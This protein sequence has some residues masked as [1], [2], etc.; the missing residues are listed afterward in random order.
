MTVAPPD[1][2]E[3]ARAML[4][5]GVAQLSATA[6]VFASEFGDGHRYQNVRISPGVQ[7]AFGD[8]VKEF[9]RGTVREARLRPYEPSYKPDDDELLYIDVEETPQ[10]QPYLAP[11]A[12]AGSQQLFDESPD[13]ID[14]LRF[15]L[16]R[17]R[18]AARAGTFISSY[19]PTRE[20]TRSRMLAV[21]FEGGN[22]NR[23]KRRT[24]LFDG[25]FDCFE[26]AG[27]LFIKNPSRFERIFDYIAELQTQAE[28]ALVTI[29]QRVPIRDFDGLTAHALRNPQMTAKLASLAHRSYLPTLTVAALKAVIAEFP[30]LQQQIPIVT[31]G[32]VEKLVFD[33]APSRRWAILKLLDDD[34]LRSQMTSQHYEVNS[35]VPT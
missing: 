18:A 19:G 4:I 16:L 27:L 20:L 9:V 8:D 24:F 25:R 31:E 33:P 22:F 29:A 28:S 21:I 23:L 17:I 1:P 3:A 11:A 32:G 2:A 12:R 7:Q 13:F 6:L 35:K 10:L 15:F 14:A 34:Y 30:K 5:E 26:F